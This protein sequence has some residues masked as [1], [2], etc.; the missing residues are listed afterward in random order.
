LHAFG[1]DNAHAITCDALGRVWVGH[2]N[3]GVSVFNG[4][5]WRNYD[6]PDG[7]RGERVFAMTTSPIDGAV[8][9]ATSVQAVPG[10]GPAQNT[11]ASSNRTG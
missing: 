6:V 4:L 7:P 9:I 8:R 10:R 11:P 3:H 1:T 2:L 5:T